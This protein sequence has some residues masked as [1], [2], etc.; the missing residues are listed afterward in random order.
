MTRRTRSATSAALLAL[1]AVTLGAGHGD[2]AQRLSGSDRS[3]ADKA[4]DAGRIPA[5]VVAFLGISPGA[6]V[7]DVIA[8][9]YTTANVAIPNSSSLVGTEVFLQAATMGPGTKLGTSARTELKFGA[10]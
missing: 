4:R 1:A 10:R 6:T 5:D 3:D 8:A 7:M 9:G 2:L